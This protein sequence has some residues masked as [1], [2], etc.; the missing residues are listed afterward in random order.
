MSRKYLIFVV[1]LLFLLEGCAPSRRVVRP[2]QKKSY[3]ASTKERPSKKH[4]TLK[5]KSVSSS[6]KR[7]VKAKGSSKK[8]QSS[9]D[10]VVNRYLGVRY[11]SGGTS[12]KGFDCS[13]LVWKIYQ[14]MGH[15]NFKRTPARHMYKLG[16]RVSRKNLRKG[17]LC[18]FR[19]LKHVG[20]YMGEGQFVHAS[21]SKGVIY[22][23]LKDHYWSRR[24][25]GFRR[26]Y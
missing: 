16:K 1:T 18:F 7:S 4:A 12:R 5:K 6:K 9:F 13:G 14:D 26:I 21:S 10:K 25:V 20:I 2:S 23:S 15:T 11:R 19:G 24:I 3:R 17:D 8:R 22:T